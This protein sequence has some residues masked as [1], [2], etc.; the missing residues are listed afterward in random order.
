MNSLGRYF[1]HECN[2]W[3]PVGAF[4]DEFIALFTDEPVSDKIMK[5]VSIC[6]SYSQRYSVLVFWLIVYILQT[7]VTRYNKVQ[8][9]SV[10]A[11]QHSLSSISSACKWLVHAIHHVT[12]KKFWCT[13][14]SFD[15]LRVCLCGAG[16]EIW[17]QVYRRLQAASAARNRMVTFTPASQ[18]HEVSNGIV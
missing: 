11:V 6:Q 14:D 16:S 7:L 1:Q 2:I 18:L 15:V 9:G 5:I 4:D 8:K 13:K 12:W 3:W 10:S 17:M